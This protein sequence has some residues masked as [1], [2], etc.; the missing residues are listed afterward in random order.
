MI[1]VSN[2]MARWLLIAYAAFKLASA[3]WVASSKWCHDNISVKGSIPFL[4]VTYISCILSY[5]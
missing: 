3:L 4:S 5:K 1:L 2:N